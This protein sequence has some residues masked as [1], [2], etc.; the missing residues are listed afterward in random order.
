MLD[1]DNLRR[2]ESLKIELDA[3]VQAAYVVD[4]ESFEK[5]WST[6]EDLIFK[7]RQHKIT[8]PDPSDL[9]WK[10]PDGFE[11]KKSKTLRLKQNKRLIPLS[12]KQIV[13]LIE[14]N[15]AVKSELPSIDSLSTKESSNE[16]MSRIEYHESNTEL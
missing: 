1:L 3:K 13:P 10:F 11:E 12:G 8:S 6:L 5:H 4:P 15:E 2:V 14:S 16:P 7:V 9:K